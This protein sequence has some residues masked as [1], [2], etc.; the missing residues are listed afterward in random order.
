LLL[1]V[2]GNETTRNNI[3]HGLIA[4][5]EHPDQMHAL[6]D[7]PS[8]LLSTAV[9]E[10]TRWA[11]PV[12]YMART[13]VRDTEVNGQSLHAGD[14]VAMFY[15]SANRDEDVFADA[16]VFDIERTPNKHVAFG[17]GKHF[18]LGANLA[19]IETRVM[20]S[21]LLPRIVDVELAAPI[22]RLRSS[23]IHGVKHLP[24]RI[25]PA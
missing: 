10:I 5:M 9:E 15:A 7:D 21:E 20:F 22:E 25:V 19:R 2:A 23:F 8:R 13:V 1:L 16:D 11:S 18:C 12:N 24:V 3:S 4:L 17:V 14:R 6:R